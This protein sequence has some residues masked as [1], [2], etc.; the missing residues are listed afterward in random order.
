MGWHGSCRPMFINTTP[1]F[2]SCEF[3]YTGFRNEIHT[4]TGV[5]GVLVVDTKTC[6]HL[7][8]STTCHG[9]GLRGFFCLQIATDVVARAGQPDLYAARRHYNLSPHE[10]HAFLLYTHDDGGDV[11]EQKFYY[12]ENADL[13]R[14]PHAT[15]EEQRAIVS[16]WAP[17]LTHLRSGLN[18]MPAYQG[19]VYRGVLAD[20]FEWE[21][22][23]VG[24]EIRFSGLTSC[25]ISREFAVYRAGLAGWLLSMEI[26][27]GRSISV[28]SFFPDEDEILLPPDIRCVIVARRASEDEGVRILEV[29]ELRGETLLS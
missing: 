4:N 12:V 14:H 13:R 15:A 8:V 2:E 18:K 20:A 24:R 28:F 16:T 10:V 25:S 6:W 11:L 17:H 7:S 21:D 3:T 29:L 9:L 1:R 27:S 23:Y 5:K 19:C 26:F 22:M